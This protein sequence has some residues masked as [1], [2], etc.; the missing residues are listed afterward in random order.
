MKQ[1]KKK[2]IHRLYAKRKLL[3][4]YKHMMIAMQNVFD[5]RLSYILYM[6]K[7]LWKSEFV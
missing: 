1:T 3:F 5:S 6:Y 7:P 2:N 4:D